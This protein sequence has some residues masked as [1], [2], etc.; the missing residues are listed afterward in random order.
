MTPGAYR[1]EYGHLQ[2]RLV[3]KGD[4]VVRGQK[5]ALMG[6][7]GRSTGPHLHYAIRYP[8]ASL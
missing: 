5:I 7:T 8:E 4:R 2:K 3:K 1:T 6:N